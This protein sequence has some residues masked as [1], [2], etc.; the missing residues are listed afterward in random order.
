[1]ILTTPNFTI[2]N[3][4]NTLRDIDKIHAARPSYFLSLNMPNHLSNMYTIRGM[5]I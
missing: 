1:M 4:Q 2:Y 5:G 3:T